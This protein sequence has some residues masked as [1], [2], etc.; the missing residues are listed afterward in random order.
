MH[1]APL[2]IERDPVVGDD[3]REALRDVAELENRD[4][5]HRCGDSTASTSRT[6][7]GKTRGRVGPPSRSDATP[8]G[9]Y[10]NCGRMSTT[11]IWPF[12]I[13]AVTA[14]IFAVSF[15]VSFAFLAIGA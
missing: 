10:L 4:A 6:K 2:E 1:L 11:L 3:A 8:V 14:A 9:V 15:A 7:P 5:G 13:L 12:F